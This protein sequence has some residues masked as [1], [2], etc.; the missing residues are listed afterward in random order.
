MTGGDWQ[1][2][3]DGCLLLLSS[4]VFVAVLT[5]ARVQNMESVA[6]GQAPKFCMYALVEVRSTG[7]FFDTI[8]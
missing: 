7:L 8:L 3:A 1:R 4:G 5:V 2:L 6:T